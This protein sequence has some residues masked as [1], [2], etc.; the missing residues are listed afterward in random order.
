VEST[1]IISG[2]PILAQAA[3]SHSVPLK[4]FTAAPGSTVALHQQQATH[5]RKD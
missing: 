1:E 2:E 4:C 5:Q 3:L